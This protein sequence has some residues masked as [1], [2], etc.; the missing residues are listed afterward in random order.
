M[1]RGAGVIRSLSKAVASR[2]VQVTVVPTPVKFTERRAV[3][4]ALQ[5]F[6]KIE[7]FRKLEVSQHGAAVNV[8]V[9][10]I[11]LDRTSS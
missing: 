6:A 9:D 4:H 5:K 7:V 8:E 10:Q 2:T 1:S 11:G 3:L